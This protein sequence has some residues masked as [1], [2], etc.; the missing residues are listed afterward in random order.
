LF[1]ETKIINCV[2]LEISNG[3]ETISFKKMA[4]TY[5]VLTRFVV[6]SYFTLG[7]CDELFS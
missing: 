6:Q 2:L 4:V 5:E 7:A 3:K 1:N